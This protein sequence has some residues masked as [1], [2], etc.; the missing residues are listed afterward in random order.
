VDGFLAFNL[1]GR[2]M[3]LLNALRGRIRRPAVR[4]RSA[5]HAAMRRPPV[6][7][8]LEDRM[9]PSCTLSLVPSEPAP[10][11]VGERILWTATASDCGKD[12]VYQFRVGPAGGPFHLVRDFSLDNAFTWTPMQEGT[13]EVQVT[14]KEG[15]QATE[16][17]S[18]IVSD[19]V[20][21][22]VTG[23]DA[24]ITPTSNPL[25][26][27]YSAPACSE[28]TIRVEFAEAGH[29]PDWQSTNTLPC[30]PR[31]S[32]NFVVAGMLPDTIYQVRHV[33]SDHHHIWHSSPL[34]FTSG[35]LPADL[36]FYAFTVR[37]PPGHHS[38]LD[39][40]MIYHVLSA[41]VGQEPNPAPLAT[42]LQGRVVW[43]YDSHGA[44]PGLA[45]ELGDTLLPGGTLL[46]Y[47]RDQHSS[48]AENV[49]R[50]VDLA[51]NPLRE[52]NL[53][54]VNAQLQA[55]GHEI[56]YGFS[57]DNIR[58]ANGDTVVLG[59][60]ERTV[61]IDGTPT[62]YIGDMVVVLDPELQVTWAWDA[63]DHLDVN[64]GPV[65][66]EVCNPGDLGPACVVGVASHQRHQFVTCGRQPDPVRPS[67]GLGDQD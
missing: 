7:E 23:R 9:L 64:R 48:L 29:H 46:V 35:S 52:T 31:L 45:L 62:D 17:V 51:G 1:G 22:R 18:D 30:E 33:L 14:A 56:I 55:L 26:T 5:F 19:A 61:D 60:T 58:L 34:L 8:A 42:D 67:S 54:V 24:V 32:R 25:V 41:P 57:H 49:L 59:Y 66:G 36:T 50:E 44:E 21:S 39:Q 43:Y 13:Y 11:L 4:R 20:H 10:Q 28:G 15:Y 16:T 2:I 38:D 3:Y 27:L 63:F 6:L 47:G 37:Q 53:D 12:L 40:D 65:L